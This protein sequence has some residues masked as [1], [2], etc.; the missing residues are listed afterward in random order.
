MK[1]NNISVY[2][3]SSSSSHGHALSASGFFFNATFSSSN[4]WLIDYG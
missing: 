3:S 4:E 2:S 1:N